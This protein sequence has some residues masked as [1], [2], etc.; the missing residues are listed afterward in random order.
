MPLLSAVLGSVAP[1]ASKLAEVVNSL[2]P[3]AGTSTTTVT[4]AVASRSR[5]SRL[6][7]TVWPAK[8]QLPEAAPETVAVDTRSLSAG[9]R[10]AENAMLPVL[11]GPRLV[12]A[13]R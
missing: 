3:S 5:P 11:L 6:Q 8:L 12:A 10:L 13:K 2:I 1:A 7:L 9:S 4:V